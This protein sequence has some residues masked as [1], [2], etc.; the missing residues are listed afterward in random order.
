[1]D[2]PDRI[3][4]QVW[5]RVLARPEETAKQE[6]RQLQRE[7]MELAAVY[8]NLLGQLTGKPREQALV[9]HMGE[10]A[11]AQTLAGIGLLS[12][13]GGENLKLWQPG[14]EPP[15]KVLERC[16]HRT[17][18]CMTAYMARSAEGEFGTVFRTLADRE[19]QHCALIA[20][21]LGSLQ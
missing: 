19:A 17:R 10:K 6:L 2:K 1:M 13:Q 15:K 4:Q 18:R 20:Q 21:L 16:Y 7:A 9:L 3:E 14:Q 5:Q 12:R 11:N 8:R